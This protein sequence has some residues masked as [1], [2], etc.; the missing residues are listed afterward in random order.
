MSSGFRFRL[1]AALQQRA[2]QEQ[3]LQIALANALQLQTSVQ[4]ALEHMRRQLADA[5][6]ST[7]AP[8]S[9]FGLEQRM[10]LLLHVD[11]ANRQV[12]QQNLL[13][14]QHAQEVQSVHQQLIQASARRRTL[15]RLREHQK[16][17]YV[18]DLQRRENN[19]LDEQGTMRYA[20]PGAE[21]R[22]LD[23]SVSEY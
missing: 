2:R 15:E 13:V 5:Q 17:E 9:I 19:E 16:D 7:T 23:A 8:G 4:Q 10:H 22:E 6:Q 12:H 21:R 18:R 3:A 11:R 1:D 14:E 20:R